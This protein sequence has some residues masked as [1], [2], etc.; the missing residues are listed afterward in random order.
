[1][2]AQAVVAA[3]ALLAYAW[4]AGAAGTETNYCEDPAAGIQWQDLVD[5]HPADYDLQALHALRIGLCEKVERGDL[6]VPQATQVFE[7]ARTALVSQK[8][9]QEAQETRRKGTAL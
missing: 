4:S 9:E 3:A 5:K 7:R 1:M 6:T 8:V 2:K